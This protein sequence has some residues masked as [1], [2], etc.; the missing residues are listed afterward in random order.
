MY[1]MVLYDNRSLEHLGE[2]AGYTGKDWGRS[3]SEKE[4]R[5][6]TNRDCIFQT[7]ERT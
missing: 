1:N 6:A 4:N 7:T 3:V 5:E 2:D